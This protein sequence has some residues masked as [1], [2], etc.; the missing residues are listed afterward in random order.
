M[1][2]YMSVSIRGEDQN[3]YSCIQHLIIWWIVDEFVFLGGESV[4]RKAMTSR[5]VQVGIEGI[6]SSISQNFFAA[7][8][9]LNEASRSPARYFTSN[10]DGT[11]W[12]PLVLRTS[13]KQAHL[14]AI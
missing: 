10:L 9:L 7:M 2:V 12:S 1:R 14:E 8:R 6:S 3:P 13:N 11:L 5:Q 4:K